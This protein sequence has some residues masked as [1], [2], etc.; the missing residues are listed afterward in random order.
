M[1]AERH[2]YDGLG[3]PVQRLEQDGGPI[4]AGRSDLGCDKSCN[5]IIKTVEIIVGI[6]FFSFFLQI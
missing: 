4:A 1:G 5:L 6:F 2:G 3:G